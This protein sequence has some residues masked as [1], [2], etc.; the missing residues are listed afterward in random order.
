[1]YYFSTGSPFSH[2]PD[3]ALNSTPF[4]SSILRVLIIQV[5]MHLKPTLFGGQ[6]CWSHMFTSRYK[7]A[8]TKVTVWEAMAPPNFIC[9][10]V[11]LCVYVLLLAALVSAHQRWSCY[12]LAWNAT[13]RV[14]THCACFTTSTLF[15]VS[16][17]QIFVKFITRFVCFVVNRI[18]LDFSNSWNIS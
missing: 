2:F 4:K 9:L 6:C 14:S 1:M 13:R 11:S 10:P 17:G 3:F 18:S 8:V 12:A 7:I 5:W 16:A 15:F